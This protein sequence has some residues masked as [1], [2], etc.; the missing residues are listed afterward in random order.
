MNGRAAWW[1]RG[2]T[3]HRRLQTLMQHAS[4]RPA[5]V[6]RTQSK[7]QPKPKRWRLQDSHVLFEI[8][9]RCACEAISTAYRS[10]DVPRVTT[11]RP[12]GTQSAAAPCT[13]LTPPP[14]AR[15]H[16]GRCLCP[17][18]THR[19]RCRRCTTTT[20]TPPHR[21]RALHT[22]ACTHHTSHTHTHQPSSAFI[23][24]SHS[25]SSRHRRRWPSSFLSAKS[26]DW[27]R[28]RLGLPCGRRSAL[29]PR[30]WWA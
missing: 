4:V 11:R 1:P 19:T 21:A 23:S 3:H 28:R 13:A 10:S 7:E 16:G 30:V 24:G 15:R 6:A 18:V 27:A 5:R 12:T 2:A 22:H 17:C 26:G 20:A 29:G 8:A 25:P 9:A 14:A